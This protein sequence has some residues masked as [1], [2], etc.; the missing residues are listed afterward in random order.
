MYD[1]GMIKAAIFDADGVIVVPEKLFSQ[2]YAE[3]SGL[4]P[5]VLQ[6]FFK[7]DFV[8]AITGRADLKDL[9]RKHADTWQWD[10]DPQELLDRWFAAEHVVDQEV[11]DVVAGQ[12]PAGVPVYLAT[13]QE[14]Y[15]ARYLREV[16]FPDVF[17][18]TF[19]SSEIGYE[20]R[21]PDYWVPV[22]GRLAADIPGI[23]PDQIVFFDDSQ[24]SVDGAAQ[25][26]LNAHLY[27]H[28]NQIKEVFS[29]L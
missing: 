13:N 23:T 15:R 4:D 5:A 2:Q 28:I 27:R 29:S 12:R 11:L 16:M 24:D 3:E 22:L 8:D 14:Q 17:D 26:G 18:G 20:K 1:K 7:G 10:R 6:T 25:A 19:V 9:I 21:H